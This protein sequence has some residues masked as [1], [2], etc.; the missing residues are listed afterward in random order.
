MASR[1]RQISPGRAA[2]QAPRAKAARTAPFHP[3]MFPVFHP[4]RRPAGRQLRETKPIH[5]AGLLPPPSRGQACFAS[6]ND[7]KGRRAMVRN[8][9]NSPTGLPADR[10]PLRQT[11]P[12]PE[13]KA[14]LTS[15]QKRDYDRHWGLQP[16]E[17][18]ANLPG[19]GPGCVA[20]S[21]AVVCAIRGRRPCRP[22]SERPA[23]RAAS[24][25][26]AG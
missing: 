17:N 2:P 15:F 19:R 12:I 18:K 16:R 20:R 4:R 8:K 26:A 23:G 11:K 1:K 7:R 3:S 24:K 21:A 13:G 14:A 9:A 22:T 6:R 5:G 10:W 25:P